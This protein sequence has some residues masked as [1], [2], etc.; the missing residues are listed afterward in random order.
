M[1]R[2]LS[3]TNG[4]VIAGAAT[5]A[6]VPAKVATK[7]ASAP[8]QCPAPPEP[9]WRG[10]DRLG[11][12][13]M[14]RAVGGVSPLGICLDWLD[15]AMHLAMAPGK[16]LSI[17]LASL[18][19]PEEAA[20]QFERY[21]H[22]PDP[23]FR[24]PDWKTW[25]FSQ[26]QSAFQ[27]LEGSWDAATHGVSGATPHDQQAVNFI[28]RQVLDMFSPSNFWFANPEV[29]E[30][31]GDTGGLNLLK[32]ARR[33][34]MDACAM[35]AG[36][37]PGASAENM[38]VFR[39]GKDIA[40]TP[41]TVIYRNDML[42]LIRYAPATS[43]T[44]RE[45]VLI[46]P[47]W[48]LKYYILDL[49]PHNSLIRYLV[50][51]GHT[52]YAISW[53]NPGEEAREWGMDEY[54]HDGLLA[55]LQEA[56]QDSGGRRIHGVGYCLGGTL[57]AITAAALARRHERRP[58]LR[59]ITLLAAQ[60]DFAEPGELGL[61]ISHSGLTF[62]D[63]LM[64]QQGY[65]DGRQLA[66]VFQL[67]NSRDLIWSRL[68]RDYLL[69]R[70]LRLT[71]LMAWNADITRLPYRMHSETLNRLYLNNDLAAGRLCVRGQ[72]VAL[73][74]IRIPMYAVATER[75]HISPWESVYK[76]HLLYHRDLTFVL[77]SGG[78]NVGIV[79][80]PGLPNRDFRWGLRHQGAAYVGPAD[81]AEQA[82]RVEGSWWPHWEAWLVRHSAPKGPAPAYPPEGAICDAPGEYVHGR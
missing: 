76:L 26:W 4:A 78:H 60:T 74:D 53:K 10:L 1:G 29:L 35:A 46:I 13:A 17:A 51:H 68:V 12:A 81:W 16:Q 25:P 43:E 47:S 70:E 6:L 2:Q 77:C 69:G 57:L 21:H 54:V 9:P 41:G 73:A 82:E 5:A 42:E 61:F 19:S 63:A 27:R 67:L 49:S 62:L 58:L 18:Q 24:H 23:R 3:S 50:Q 34:W 30:A 48:L 15:W 37:A 45:P 65:L 52:V 28:G 80:E 7:G 64:W 79:S 36:H 66:G 56:A 39:V 20:R 44:W 71:D 75:D 11:H 72:P 14:A 40:A 22:R 59:S 38:E 55:A 32:G 33:W 31:I 8:A